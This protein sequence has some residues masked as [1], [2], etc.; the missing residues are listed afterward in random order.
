MLL[1]SA[2]RTA[3]LYCLGLKKDESCF[4]LCDMNKKGLADIFF[5]EAKKI[6]QKAKLQV[7]PATKFNGQEPSTDVAVE[8]KRHDV[9]VMLTTNSLSHTNARRD[10]CKNGARVASMPGITKK[11][12]ERSLDVDYKKMGATISKL[13]ALLDT[14]KVV[15]VTTASGTNLTVELNQDSTDRDDGILNKKGAF[16]NLPAGEASLA[17]KSANGVAVIDGSMDGAERG[18]IKKPF[19]II[20][21]DGYAVDIG[22]EQLKKNLEQHNNIEV[23][24]IGEFAIGC[25]PKAIITGNVLE[26]EKVYGTCHI[27]LGDNTSYKGG[28]IWAP[29]HHDGV[30]RKP[31]IFIDGK[32]IMETGRLL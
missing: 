14:A 26:D 4:I 31:T 10:A 22:S 13:A 24:H 19:K 18:I 27:A 8:L 1:N 9:I 28:N 20:F 32:K 29:C 21:K 25:N 12:M 16:G 11:I 7:I 23:Y 2:A 5:A 17:P 6:T 3:L 15:C 30:I